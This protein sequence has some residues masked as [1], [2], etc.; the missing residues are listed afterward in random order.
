MPLGLTHFETTALRC[1]NFHLISVGCST[2][3][4]CIVVDYFRFQ[5]IHDYKCS[6][7]IVDREGRIQNNAEPSKQQKQN[8]HS[9]PCTI[10][11]S[12]DPVF[13]VILSLI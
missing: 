10:D 5:G 11:M 12:Y 3:G 2:V 1:G 6:I 7:G 9:L 8:A 4:L 13:L